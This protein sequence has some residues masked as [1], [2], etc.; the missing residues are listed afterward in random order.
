[1]LIWRGLAT[2]LSEELTEVEHALA[3]TEPLKDAPAPA[4]GFEVL[5]PK[6]KPPAEPVPPPAAPG[7]KPK[8]PMQLELAAA[9]EQVAKMQAAHM[10]VVRE[11]AKALGFDLDA[12][13]AKPVTGIADL[14][15]SLLQTKAAYEKMGVAVPGLLEAELAAVAPGGKLDEAVKKMAAMGLPKGPKPPATPELLKAA[16][17]KPGGLGP[18]EKDL[19]G[20]QLA[21]ADLSGLDLSGVILKNADLTKAKLVKTILKGAQMGKAKLA[22]ADLSG[23][24]LDKADLSGVTLDEVKFEGASLLQAVLSECSAPKAVFSGAKGAKAYLNGANLEGAVFEKAD[25]RGAPEGR[26]LRR[27]G[28]GGRVQGGR[29]LGRLCRRG[30][31]FQEGPLRQGGRLQ[32]D[33]GDGRV[34]RRGLHGRPPRDGEFRRRLAQAGEARRRGR[35]QRFLPEGLAGAGP[36]RRIE[37]LRG[38]FREGRPLGGRLRRVQPVRRGVPRQRARGDEAQRGER[39]Y[40][41]AG[42]MR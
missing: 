41:E 5:L 6:P 12:A 27:E 34:R 35:D 9:K 24:V 7:P 26:L 29:P 2:V 38:H 28:R 21:G 33:L 4:A 16:A 3:V 8:S 18:K 36:G 13:M 32:V 37:F 25:G 31:R 30:R 23:A 22:G 39:A 1:M 15:A 19:T 14:Q 17:A 10:E 42:V 20:A 11:Q 40:D